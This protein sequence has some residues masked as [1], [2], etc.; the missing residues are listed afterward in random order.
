MATSI[1]REIKFSRRENP[2]SHLGLFILVVFE[3][4]MEISGGRLEM[5]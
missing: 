5:H 1:M 2:L 3:V 4:G